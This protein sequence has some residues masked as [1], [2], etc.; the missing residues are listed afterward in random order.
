MKIVT[1]VSYALLAAG[2]VAQH[3]GEGLVLSQAIARKYNINRDYLL[4]I[5]QELTR[6]QILRSKKGPNGGLSLAK[7][8]SK[9]T[10]LDIIEAVQGPLG[11]SLNPTA[12]APREKFALRAEK[13]YEKAVAQARAT[14]K[15]VRLSDL[16]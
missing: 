7:P 15:K 10:L 2:Y 11:G 12:Y 14:L 9:I 8:A 16:I 3:K 5:M 1:S 13:A 4:R 6:A